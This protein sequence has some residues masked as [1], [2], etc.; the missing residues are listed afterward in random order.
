MVDLK[1]NGMLYA[2]TD[3]IKIIGCRYGGNDG[4]EHFKK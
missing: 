3:V 1:W 2:L 4:R